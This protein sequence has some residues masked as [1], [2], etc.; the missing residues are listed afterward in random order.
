LYG[1][2]QLII[3][4]PEGS[5]QNISLILSNATAILFNFKNTG[6]T[7]IQNVLCYLY[8]SVGSIIPDQSAYSDSSGRIQF[9]LVTTNYNRLVCSHPDYSAYSEVYNPVYFTSYTITLSSPTGFTTIP[10][11]YISYSPNVFFNGQNTSLDVTFV[12]PYNNFVSYNYVFTF[13]GNVT[14]NSGSISG[15]ESFVSN[16]FIPATTTSYPIVLNFSFVLDDGSTYNSVITYNTVPYNSKTLVHLG[17][18]RYGM[19]VGDRIMFV[20]FILIAMT[21]LVWV[22]TT[23][24]MISLAVAGFILMLFIRSGFL[25][26]DGTG[27]FKIFIVITIAYFL[28]KAWYNR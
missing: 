21:G 6:G 12:S 26:I 5:S 16:F 11:G 28:L 18:N 1:L 22:C 25:G 7:S 13:N 4:V 8:T 3:S 14:T 23:S 20:T 19:L 17:E 24:V 2:K 10:T 15:G 9:L 27:A